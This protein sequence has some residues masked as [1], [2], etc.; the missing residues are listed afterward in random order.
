MDELEKDGLL[1]LYILEGHEPVH[2]TDAKAWSWWMEQCYKDENK[3]RVALNSDGVISV[4]TVFLG[5]D[6]SLF[7]T[8]PL[9][10]ETMIFGGERDQEMFRYSTWDEAEANHK[11][12]CESIWGAGNIPDSATFVPT[13]SL[14]AQI[15]DAEIVDPDAKEQDGGH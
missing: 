4:S 5:I 3:R 14:R 13:L 1:G 15:F 11:V 6:H 12:V 7:G 9:L 2:V 10:F 8:K